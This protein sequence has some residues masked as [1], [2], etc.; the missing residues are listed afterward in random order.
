MNWMKQLVSR[1]G[2]YDDLSEEMRQ[3]IEEK[4]EELVADGMPRADA[5]IIM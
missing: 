4:V 1:R 5:S 3:H 2:L